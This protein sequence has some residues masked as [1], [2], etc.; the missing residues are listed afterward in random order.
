MSASSKSAGLFEQGYNCAQST[1]AVFS[2][3]LGIDENT[4][5]KVASGFGA[6][7]G[8]RGEMCGAV[9]GAYMAIGMKYGFTRPS[10]QDKKDLTYR[11]I[12]EFLDEFKKRNGSVYC[13]EL[14]GY[15]TGDSDQLREAREKNVFREI[16][17][18]FV[19]DSAEILERLFRRD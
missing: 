14:I 1:L 9:V 16:C 4:A 13:R 5:Y 10:E 17:P 18:K 12:A 19:R 7:L 2:T 15:E 8:Y 3:D 6:G 11:L